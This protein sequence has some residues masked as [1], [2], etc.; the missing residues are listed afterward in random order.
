MF[1]YYGQAYRKYYS[2]VRSYELLWRD[3]QSVVFSAI[4]AGRRPSNAVVPPHLIS[5]KT[6]FY[7]LIFF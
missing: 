1:S 2:K 6:M 5:P 3:R 4:L 7:V